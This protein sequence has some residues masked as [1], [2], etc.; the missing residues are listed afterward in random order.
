MKE[1]IDNEKE[2]NDEEKE[3]NH[4]LTCQVMEKSQKKTF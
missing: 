3:K 4:F 1:K 2:K